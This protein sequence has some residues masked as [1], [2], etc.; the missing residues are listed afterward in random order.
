MGDSIDNV[1]GVPGIGEKGARD[2]I[3][4]TDRS[5][6]C[7]HAADDQAEEIPRRPAH[8]RRSG[9]A[10]PRAGDAFAPMCDVPFEAE[11]FRFR[12]ADR[13]RCYALFSKME[14]RTLVPE[15]APTASSVDKDYALIDSTE[16]LTALVAEM[17][18]AGRFSMKVSPTARR[19]C[20]RRWSA[21]RFRQG[22]PGALHPARSRGLRRRLLDCRRPR[23][24][25]SWRRC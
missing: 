4:N 10:E 17:K 18:A 7:S 9:A 6:R 13:E 14:F 2:L 21:S 5:N 15:F 24:S 19:R 23:R 1:K 12:G 3:A 8:T 25:P 22:R 20:A 11:R 16:D